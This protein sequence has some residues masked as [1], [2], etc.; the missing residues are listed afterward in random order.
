VL[1]SRYEG[2]P[3]VLLEAG[4]CGTY[5]LA[6]DCP[7]GI[8]EIIRETVN[9]EI[10]DITQTEKFADKIKELVNLNFDKESISENIRSRFSKEIIIGKYEKLFDNL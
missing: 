4:V 5:S 3:N 2:F 10:Y 6:N 7:G 1:S 8:T 9:G